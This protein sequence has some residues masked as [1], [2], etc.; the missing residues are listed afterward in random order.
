MISNH[1]PIFMTVPLSAVSAPISLIGRIRHWFNP[2][3]SVTTSLDFRLRATVVIL[4]LAVMR[5]IKAPVS[6]TLA[7]VTYEDIHPIIQQDALLPRQCPR[8]ALNA[9]TLFG[10]RDSRTSTGFSE[11]K[12]D[13]CGWYCDAS[14]NI[15]KSFTKNV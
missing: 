3:T 6:N 15:T 13:G 9:S 4:A 2:E 5:P 10:L 12:I 14:G 7:S 11:D 8:L 1:F